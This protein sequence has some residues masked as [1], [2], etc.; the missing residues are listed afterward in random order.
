M[1]VNIRQAEFFQDPY[2]FYEKI[3]SSGEPLW[4]EHEQDSSSRGVWLFSRYADAM[5]V[6]KNTQ[7]ISKNI[8]SVRT[9]AMQHPFDLHL[10]HRDGADHLRLRRLVAEF[11]AIKAVTSLEGKIQAQ[12]NLLIDTFPKDVSFDFVEVFCERLPLF[13]IA[14]IIGIP[15]SDL[16]KIRE[17]SLIL[18]DGFDS[19]LAR[20]ANLPARQVALNEF[21]LYVQQLVNVKKNEHDGS[22]LNFLLE[23]KD[24][25]SISIEEL[26]GMCLFLLFAGHE[27][28]INLLGNGMSALLSHPD[29]WCLLKAEPSLIPSAV[30]EIL[31]FESPEQR[32]SFRITTAPVTIGEWRLEAGQQL[33]VFIGSA[34]RDS[35]VFENPDQF[36]IRRQHNPHLAFGIG[37]HHCLGKTLSRVEARIALA[38]LVQRCPTLQLAETPFVWRQNSFFRGLEKLIVTLS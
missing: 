4:L 6:F 2:P 32:T 11:F 3:R 19:L 23:Q 26:V 17:W 5:D 27:T 8:R 14:T 33:G 7:T 25:D 16:T 38:T 9:H 21:T 13:V 36:D 22:L 34:N 15:Y 12:V 31:R 18:G 37:L 35:S 28:T 20:H 10:L 1:S 29:Q 24:S 30:E